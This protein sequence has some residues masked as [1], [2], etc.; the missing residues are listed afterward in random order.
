MVNDL[1]AKTRLLQSVAP[2][3]VKGAWS[4]ERQL[5][6]PTLVNRCGSTPQLAH[7]EPDISCSQSAKARYHDT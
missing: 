4:D 3:V 1:Q 6:H 5:L 2:H 7:K